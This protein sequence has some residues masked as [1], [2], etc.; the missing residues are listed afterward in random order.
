MKI[1]P[2]IE[3]HRQRIEEEAERRKAERVNSFD[4]SAFNRRMIL[5][6]KIAKRARERRNRRTT[7][8]ASRDEVMANSGKLHPMERL[9]KAA[10][11]RDPAMIAD[12]MD[13]GETR[14]LRERQERGEVE[15]KELAAKL[16]SLRHQVK[17]LSLTDENHQASSSPTTNEVLTAKATLSQTQERLRS[18]SQIVLNASLAIVALNDMV[19]SSEADQLTDFA[20]KCSMI[21]AKRREEVETDSRQVL[22]LIKSLH[23]EVP[24]DINNLLE[25]KRDA[26]AD[27]EQSS[28][29]QNLRVLNKAEVESLFA[30]ET[31]HLHDIAD[32][33]SDEEYNEQNA[34][35][36][37][38][39]LATFVHDGIS[40]NASRNQQRRANCLSHAKQGKYA[41]KGLVLEAVLAQGPAKV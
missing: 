37:F 25:Q 30:T 11:T 3:E 38:G 12:M 28:S 31:K 15:L 29:Y 21:E 18:T 20:I 23:S 6:G 22:K 13:D 16:E 33:D 24:A 41:S 9:A 2:L 34:D 40:T 4:P 1:K 7:T 27:H 19:R 10:G 35:E 32:N 8:T 26:A 39:K 14:S 5:E 17:Q 36:D